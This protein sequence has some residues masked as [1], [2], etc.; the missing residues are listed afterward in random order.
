L[1]LKIHVFLLTLFLF[2]CVFSGCMASAKRGQKRKREDADAKGEVTALREALAD[3]KSVNQILVKEMGHFLNEEMGYNLRKH[4]F[5]CHCMARMA[6]CKCN[7]PVERE[8][9]TILDHLKTADVK[10]R[11]GASAVLSKM[12]I[13]DRKDAVRDVKNGATVKDVAVQIYESVAGTGWVRARVNDEPLRQL[14]TCLCRAGLT[15]NVEIQGNTALAYACVIKPSV[16]M[17][18]LSVTTDGADEKDEEGES[19]L[20]VACR[21]ENMPGELI[22]QLVARSSDVTLNYQCDEQSPPLF[23]AI[24]MLMDSCE[25]PD[26]RDCAGSHEVIDA[27]LRSAEPGGTGVDLLYTKYNGHTAL[28]YAIDAA[29]GMDECHVMTG[30]VDRIRAA[31]IKVQESRKQVLPTLCGVL[32][33]ALLPKDVIEIVAGY[34]VPHLEDILPKRARRPAAAAA[35]AAEHSVV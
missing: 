18:L 27:L 4:G 24:D 19:A 30:M 20:C 25:H 29:Q 34:I 26:H 31:T 2:F 22:R 16:A 17:A 14:M 10:E 33:K 7:D 28:E 32:D 15:L 8:I 3:A 9:A 11:N 35:A 5:C 6:A 23:A 13:K 1:L 21:Q 12:V